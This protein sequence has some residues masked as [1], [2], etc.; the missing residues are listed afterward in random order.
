MIEGES[1]QFLEMVRSAATRMEALVR[2]LLSYTQV[3]GLAPPA[4]RVDANDILKFDPA[5]GLGAVHRLGLLAI[6]QLVGRFLPA[7]HRGNF[8]SGNR[9]AELLSIAQHL[10]YR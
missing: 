9:L 10:R 1:K 3:T 8:R 4:D 6:F 7:T 2:D 5:E